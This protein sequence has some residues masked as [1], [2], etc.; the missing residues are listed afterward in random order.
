MIQ[1]V[2]AFIEYFDGVRR[3]TSNFIRALP[4][5]RIDWSPKEGEWTCG[6]IVRHLAAAE[7]MF[8]GVAVEGRWG[9]SGHDESLAGSLDE[10]VAHLEHCH[11]EAM[12]ALRGLSDADL[13][14]P[15][16]TL[17][18]PPAKAWRLLMAMVEHEVHHRSQLAVYLAL[19]GVEPPQ[20]YGLGIEDVIALSASKGK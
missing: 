13:Y 10:A 17:N 6:E 7:K 18:G 5:D 12:A 20:I 11:S 2:S 16:P 8:I 19:M 9:Y 14:Q 3:R 4:A 1:S 15:R